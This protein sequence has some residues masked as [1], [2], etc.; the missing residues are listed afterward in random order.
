VCAVVLFILKKL[1]SIEWKKEK[2]SSCLTGL[3]KILWL[4]CTARNCLVVL[5]ASVLAGV[6]ELYSKYPFSMTD[7]T[8]PGLPEFKFPDFSLEVEETVGNATIVTEWGTSDI[9]SY[10][11]IGLLITPLVV[12]VEAFAVGKSFARVNNYQIDSNQELIAL[13]ASDFMGSFVSSYPVTGSF[14][15]TAVNAA[16]GVKT[17]GGQIYTGMELIPWIT[18]FIIS[19]GLG[20]EYGFLSGVGVSI[21]ARPEIKSYFPGDTDSKEHQHVMVIE[22]EQGLRFPGIE[23]IKSKITSIVF[24]ACPSLVILDATHMA[25][26]DYTVWM[27][28]LFWLPT[29]TIRTYLWF[30]LV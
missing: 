30:S 21:W 8:E 22:L 18:T 13:G 24:P 16:S 29:S 19:L 14:S 12:V 23:Y 10:I 9:L 3:Q 5:L 17:P 15:R 20:V 28:C 2:V 7:S 26:I 1:R 4:I 11:G 27:D 25:N 6:L